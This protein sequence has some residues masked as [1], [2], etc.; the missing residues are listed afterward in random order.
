[1]S[2]IR[3]NKKP[4]H[5]EE[6][7]ALAQAEQ[8]LDATRRRVLKLLHE[9]GAIDRSTL[10]VLLATKCDACWQITGVVERETDFVVTISLPGVDSD[11][12]DLTA[13]PREL[14]VAAKPPTYPVPKTM[15]GR[16]DLPIDLQSDKVKASLHHG[17]LV[18]VAP[19]AV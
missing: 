9:R 18:I 11:L 12:S 2:E 6:M 15:S 8:V 13:E 19:K 10:Y 4:S 17:A 14:T 3:I 7:A 1:M 5:V 16:L